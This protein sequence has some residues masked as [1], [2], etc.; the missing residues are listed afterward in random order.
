MTMAT[1]LPY[2]VYYLL[3]W[4]DD[5]VA[6]VK[7]LADER[8]LSTKEIST[9]ANL[10][11]MKEVL[12]IL[13]RLYVCDVISRNKYGKDSNNPTYWRITPSYL[14]AIKRFLSKYGGDEE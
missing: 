10:N 1:G 9:M 11:L 8:E 13:N 5:A 7:L 4:N 12:P 3:N 6:V 2:R 14:A